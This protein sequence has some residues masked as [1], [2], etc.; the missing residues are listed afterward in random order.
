MATND[1]TREKALPPKKYVDKNHQN[2]FQFGWLP[3][4]KARSND[5]A[6]DKNPSSEEKDLTEHD[7]PI[8]LGW[9]QQLFQQKE[10]KPA[11]I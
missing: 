10:S 7:N 11:E 8:Q 3:H 1:E 2:I 4:I 9:F 5:E 6:A